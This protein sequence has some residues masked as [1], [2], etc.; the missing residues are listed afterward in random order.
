[1]LAVERTPSSTPIAR[2]R[3]LKRVALA[4]AIAFPLGAWA[5]GDEASLERGALPDTTPQQ[6][7]HT[8]IREAGGGLKVSLEECRAMGA[9]ERT[10]CE[11]A[12]RQ[13]YKADM[14]ASK[15]MLRDPN[16]RPVNIEGGPIRSTETVFIVRP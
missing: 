13:R 6:R 8:A 5:Q 11:A 4:L 16:A 1:M 7:Y 10:P 12:A 2:R 3:E 15:T 14:E 9:L